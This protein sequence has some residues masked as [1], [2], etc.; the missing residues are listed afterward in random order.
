MKNMIMTL[1]SRTFNH[2][3]QGLSLYEKNNIFYIFIATATT[4]IL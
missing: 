2:L 3:R 1:D 4:M